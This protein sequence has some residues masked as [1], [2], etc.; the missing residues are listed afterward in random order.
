MERTQEQLSKID[1]QYI[2]HPCSQM[3]DY[4]T[5]PPIVIDHGKGVYL[6]DK[7]GKR[8]LDVVS[9]W[10]CNLLGHCNEKISARMKQQL[11]K[12][13]HVIFA[14]FTHEPAI[15]LCERLVQI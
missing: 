12:L 15:Q 13:E 1:L 3:K 6:Y 2:W 7:N 5:L 9:S 4:E 8:Y 14:N 11:D 10:W